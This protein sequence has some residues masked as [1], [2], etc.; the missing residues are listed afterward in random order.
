MTEDG[1]AVTV[2]LA[3]N[4]TAQYVA[5][6]IPGFRAALNSQKRLLID[7]SATRRIDCRFFGLLL[8]LRKQLD[9]SG[10][11]L[12]FTGISSRIARLFHRNGV[13]FLLSRG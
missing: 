8:M 5:K 2:H 3:G 10:R 1:A 12:V 9:A 7:L 4:A 13:A 6:A 11:R